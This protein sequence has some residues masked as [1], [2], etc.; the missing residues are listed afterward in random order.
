MTR[1]PNA[2]TNGSSEWS[3]PPPFETTSW[4]AT[5]AMTPETT[6]SAVAIQASCRSRRAMATLPTRKVTISS[7]QCSQPKNA[8][9]IG[10]MFDVAATAEAIVPNL[11]SGSYHRSK[12]YAATTV[13]APAKKDG[14]PGRTRFGFTKG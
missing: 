5:T 2:A 11:P 10:D 14:A 7:V 4:W 6:L 8:E 13:I 9:A 3:T 12:V 1:Y